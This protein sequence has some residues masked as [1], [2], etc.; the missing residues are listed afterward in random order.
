MQVM[1]SKNIALDIVYFD[2]ELEGSSSPLMLNLL[3]PPYLET[4]R[5]R[6]VS[7]PLSRWTFRHLGDYH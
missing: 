4:S 6:V 5:P 7:D 2:L 1:R 3:R